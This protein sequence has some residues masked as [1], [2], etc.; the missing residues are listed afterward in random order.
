MCFFTGKTMNLTEQEQKIVLLD[1]V[2]DVL[3]QALLFDNVSMEKNHI[4]ADM[5]TVMLLE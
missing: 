3:F 2:R 1:N 4:R 5:C